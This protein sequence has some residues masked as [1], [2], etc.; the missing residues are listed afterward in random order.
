MTYAVPALEVLED[1]DAVARRAA[2]WLAA[3]LGEAL[4]LR[5][6]ATLAVSGGKT[7]PHA[8]AL[9]GQTNVRWPAIDVLQ[10]DERVA[11]D[12][13]RD[14]NAVAQ[15]AAFEAHA[16]RAPRRF[17]WMP[18]EEPDLDAAAAAYARELAALAGDPPI[19][20]VVHLGI[21]E[22]G[23]TASLVPGSQALEARAPV[24]VTEPYQGRR[25][26]TLTFPV[27]N[28]ARHVV[29]IVTGAGKKTALERL[30][31]GDPALVANRVRRTDA[32]VLA[33]TQAAPSA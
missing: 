15:A 29:W 32:V 2:E 10:V 26:M 22:D 17:H 8:L 23:H 18:V 1:T 20:D 3:R 5:G 30:L 24:V 16:A 13:H 14:R 11:P 7:A 12:G 19:I 28:Q 25:R 21:G 6:R 27:I 4:A 33:D 31:R 9:L